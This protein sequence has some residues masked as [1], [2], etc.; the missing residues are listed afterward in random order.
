MGR[1]AEGAAILAEL[2]AAHEGPDNERAWEHAAHRL[3]SLAQ[4]L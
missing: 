1:F 3:W 2:E 4:E